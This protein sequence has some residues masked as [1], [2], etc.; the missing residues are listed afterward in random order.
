[1]I[2]ELPPSQTGNNHSTE[3]KDCSESLLKELTGSAEAA[4]DEFR[5]IT[6]KSSV[7]KHKKKGKFSWF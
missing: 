3:I 6:P 1:M 7:L 2:P 4:S 5:T